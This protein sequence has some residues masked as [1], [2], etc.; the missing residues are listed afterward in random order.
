MSLLW[1]SAGLVI[2]CFCFLVFNFKHCF[3]MCSSLFIFFFE[4]LSDAAVL[5]KIVSIFAW[6]TVVHHPDHLQLAVVGR[7]YPQL[8]PWALA[9]LRVADWWSP[10]L[11]RYQLHS[12]SAGFFWTLLKISL[13]ELLRKEVKVGIR[14]HNQNIIKI[15]LKLNICGKNHY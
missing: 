10:N 15:C 1:G 13:I 8:S 12:G 4:F 11:Y 5:L 3:K 6:Q 9:A 2:I 14:L 7:L